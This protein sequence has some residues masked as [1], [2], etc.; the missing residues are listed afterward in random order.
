MEFTIRQETLKDYTQVYELNKIAFAQENEAELVELL[1]K[2]NAFV[3]QLS[4][5]AA[6]GSK[7]VGHILF[8]RIKI[9]N[10]YGNKFDSLALAPMA[11]APELQKQG[12]GAKLVQSGLLKAKDLAFKSVIVLGHENY[13]PKFGFKPAYLWQIKA[14]FDV[15][16]N[17]FM[18]IELVPDALKNIQ[19]TV[20]YPKEF[21]DV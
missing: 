16:E 14:P 19:G 8:T 1:R 5:V 11:V 9:A 6:V 13:Y 7:I 10:E 15:P 21:E 18:A 3:P 17:V 4:T 20:I 2:S 12:I